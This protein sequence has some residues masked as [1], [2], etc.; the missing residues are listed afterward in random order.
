MRDWR[1]S[2]QSLCAHL[3]I[4]CPNSSCLQCYFTAFSPSFL[5]A[6]FLF[7]ALSVGFG[8]TILEGRMGIKLRLSDYTS[9]Q[10][11]DYRTSKKL[12]KGSA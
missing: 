2:G 4:E 5:Q 12:K 9:Q 6:T 11:L 1:S 3:F 10:N 7:L 8:E